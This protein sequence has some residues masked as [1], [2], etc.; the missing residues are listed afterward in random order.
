MSHDS[1]NAPARSLTAR[2]APGRRPSRRAPE[3]ALPAGA[4]NPLRARRSLLRG[5]APHGRRGWPPGRMGQPFPATAVRCPASTCS[6][7]SARRNRRSHDELHGRPTPVRCSMSRRPLRTAHTEPRPLL[8]P[9]LR[10]PLRGRAVN[11]EPWHLAAACRGTARDLN[12]TDDPERPLTVAECLA[13]C[14]RCP[15]VEECAHETARHETRR[16]HIV[17]TLAGMSA[18]ERRS[19]MRNGG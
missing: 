18:R 11:R 19:K 17:G 4:G 10:G 2:R 15:V 12:W 3:R 5:P 8:R 9:L 7:V 1:L 16:E 13:V 14:A 6:V